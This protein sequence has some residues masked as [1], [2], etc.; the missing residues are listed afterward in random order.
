MRVRP[1]SALLIERKVKET[2]SDDAAN[3]HVPDPMRDSP[4]LRSHLLDPRVPHGLPGTFFPI[5]TSLACS[6]ETVLFT[7]ATTFTGPS[8]TYRDVVGGQWTNLTSSGGQSSRLSPTPLLCKF[9]SR[10]PVYAATPSLTDAQLRSALSIHH[11]WLCHPSEYGQSP[12]PQTAPHPPGVARAF[13]AAHGALT[14]SASPQ[15]L[16]ACLSSLSAADFRHPPLARR[17]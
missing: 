6:P 5:E 17:L 9:N 13:D 11:A 4:C 14:H 3:E 7:A 1:T 8:K 16:N 12:S 10:V 15:P 2:H